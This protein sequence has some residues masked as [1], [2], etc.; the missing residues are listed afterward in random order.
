MRISPRKAVPPKLRNSPAEAEP[1]RLKPLAA[2]IRHALLPG[3]LMGLHVGSAFAGPQGGKVVAGTGSIAR[4]NATST[5]IRQQSKNIAIDW[6]K[7][8]VKSN[9]LVQFKQPGRNAQALNRIF[10][11]NASQIH[12]RIK[13][14]GRVL[15][16]N[17]NGVIFGRTAKVNVNGLVAA[18]MR[19]IPVDDFMAGKY[20]LEA[21]T[22]VDGAVVN[23]GVIEAGPGGDVTLV[24]KSIR[25]DGVI[26]ASA[27]RVNLAAGNKVTLD[28]DGDGLMRFAVDESVLENVQALDDQIANTG[29]IAAEGGEVMMAASA[30]ADVFNHAINNSG[31]VRAGRIDKSGGQ[32]RLVG[33]GPGAS[34]LNTGVVDA[35][36][37]DSTSDAGFVDITGANIR[38]SGR[39]I[40]DA[41]GGDGG[42][43]KLQ[44]TGVTAVTD[45]GV[46]SAV[47]EGKGGHVELLGE[48]VGVLDHATIDASGAAGGGEV[49]IGG[50]YQGANSDVQN[51]KLTVIAENATV[52][53]D[54]TENGD[55]GKVIAW[56]DE[57]TLF[58]GEISAKG[59]P[60]GGD[61]GFVETSGKEYL[62]ARGQVSAAAPEGTGG[63]WLLDPRDITILT[64]ATTA[65]DDSTG[66]DPLAMPTA[67]AFDLS[68]SPHTFDSAADS[69]QADIDQIVASLEGGTSVTITTGATGVAEAGDITVAGS[70]SAD[71]A[72]AAVTLSL[73][74]LND[75]LFNAGL[76]VENTTVG[77][78]T[79]AFDL[80]FGG[81]LDGATLDFNDAT[82]AVDSLSITGSANASGT[83]LVNFNMATVGTATVSAAVNIDL[84]SGTN[85]VRLADG[86]YTNT[87]AF[88]I[89]G[90]SGTE[91][92]VGPNAVNAWT[93]TGVDDAGLTGGATVTLTDVETLTGGS[94]ADTFNIDNTWNGA[95]NGGAGADQFIFADTVQVTGAGTAIDGGT[96]VDT[97]NWSMSVADVNVS[98][99]AIGTSDGVA[100][101]EATITTGTFDNIDA[102][103]GNSNANSSLTGPDGATNTWTIGNGIDDGTND[104]TLGTGGRTLDYTNVP[105]LIGGDD[106]DNFVVSAGTAGTIGGGSG[107]TDTLTG[108][109]AANMFVLT[110][111]NIGTLTGVVGAF[112]NIDALIG[113]A[114]ADTLTFSNATAVWSGSFDGAGGGSDAVSWINLTNAVDVIITEADANGFDG[115]ALEVGD[116]AGDTTTFTDIEMI[117]SSGAGTDSLTL[118]DA[119]T[120][121]DAEWTIVG[122]VDDGTLVVA[123]QTLNFTDFGSWTG[124]AAIDTFNVND[125]TADAT[126]DLTGSIDG[127]GGNDVFDLDG[128][129]TIGGTLIGGTGTADEIAGP[130]AANTW[131]VT[132]DAA[133]NFV[134]GADNVAFTGVERLQGGS[135]TDN[136]DVAAGA[137]N[138]FVD[139]GVNTDTIDWVDYGSPVSVT[140]TTVAAANGYGGAS[141]TGLAGF[142]NIE[143]MLAD[144]V[145]FGSLTLDIA[146]GGTFTLNGI[147][148]ANAYADAGTT[149]TLSF[150]DFRTL[151]GSSAAVD[152][153]DFA[154]SG[155]SDFF[156]L[157]G[158]TA[159]AEIDLSAD[160]TDRLYTL[161]ALNTGVVD[162]LAFSNVRT[163]TA[164]GGDAMDFSGSAVMATID[165]QNSTA[166]GIL[167]AGFSGFSDF[168]GN[169]ANA[170]LRAPDGGVTVNITTDNDGDV[171]AVMF[172]NFENLEGGT[173]ADMF[174]FSDTVTVGDIVG[175]GGADEID[176]SVYVAG[177]TFD[178]S[179]DDTGTVN[180][181]TFTGVG[182]LTGGLGNDMLSIDEGETISG[183]F[184][185]AG[186]SDTIDW[187]GLT[188][189]SLTIAITGQG[190]GATGFAGTE[191]TGDGGGITLSSFDNVEVLTGGPNTDAFTGRDVVG[192][193]FSL[194][195]GAGNSYTD[196]S[197]TVGFS[198]LED[199]T[200]STTNATTFTLTATDNTGAADVVHT[201]DLTGSG[202]DDS[203]IFVNDAQLAGQI[204]AGTGTNDQIDTNGSTL[205]TNEIKIL[206]NGD[207]E[208]NDIIAFGNE[209]NINADKDDFTGIE[210]QTG[211]PLILAGIDDMTNTWI[212][213]GLGAVTLN[214]IMYTNVDSIVL[215]NDVDNV[216]FQAT[217]ELTNGVN[218][219]NSGDDTLI[220]DLAATFT[221][222]DVG[223]GSIDIGVTTNFV[224]IE[225]LTGSAMADMFDFTGGGTLANTLTT[226]G[227]A[228]MLDVSAATGAVTVNLQTNAL[229]LVN[230]GGAGGINTF[231]DLTTVT[232]GGGDDIVIAD[233]T[234][235]TFDITDQDD[236]TVGGVSFIDFSNLQSGTAGDTFQF[237]GVNAEI[238]GTI[239]GDAGNGGTLDYSLMTGG[240]AA[241]VMVN[242]GDSSATLVN[243]GGA[244]GISNIDAVVGADGDDTLRGDNTANVF[245]ITD[246]DDGDIDAGA[247]TFTDFSI[248]E[249]GTAG[250]TFRFNGVSAA[251]TGTVAGDATNGGT[252]DYSLMTGG[253]AL[254][255]DV[256]LET[257]SASLVFAGAASGFTNI[258]AVTGDGAN[259]ALTGANASANTFN[260]TNAN[261]GNIGGAFA[262]T[263]FTILNAGTSGD[264]FVFT[265]TGT[266]DTI[267]GTAGGTDTVSYAS[268][269]GPVSLT[270]APVL[271]F[272]QV[273]TAT[274]INGVVGSPLG[275]TFTIQPGGQLDAGTGIDGGGGSDTV[276]TQESTTET[277]TFSVTGANQGSVSFPA[278]TTFVSIE[279]L[280]GTGNN[281]AFTFTTAASRIANVIDGNGGAAD[282]VT[283]T[284]TGG[285]TVNID[286]TTDA[287]TDID[288]IVGAAADA[289]FFLAGG[290]AFTVTSTDSGSVDGATTTGMTFTNWANLVGTGA[291]DLFDF[292]SGDVSGT[293][294]GLGGS[295]T[296]DFANHDDNSTVVLLLAGTTD[297][298]QGSLTDTGGFDNIDGI[299]GR[300][301]GADSLTGLD[302]TSTWTI[303][304]TPQY[305]AAAVTFDFSEVETI[306]G[307]TLA[308]NFVISN[309]LGITNIDGGADPNPGVDTIDA[310]AY[311]ASALTWMINA[312]GGGS[313]DTTVAINFA[314]IEA[315]VGG[316]MTDAFTVT[317]NSGLLNLFG[318]DPGNV[319]G[320]GGAMNTID[321]SARST[322]V[323]VELPNISNISTVIG[324]TSMNDQLTGTGAADVFT[325]TSATD[326]GTV[327]GG[328]TTIYN[329]FENLAGGG[330]ADD[331]VLNNDVTG[332]VTGDA[333]AD[334]FFVQMN[335][336][337]IGGGIDGGADNDTVI[338]GQA[339]GAGDAGD[340][341]V[342]LTADLVGG[343]GSDTFDFR[344]GSTLVG[345]V[346]G[347]VATAPAG[348]DDD[349][350]TIDD[351]IEAQFSTLPT[352][353]IPTG[354]GS[355]GFGLA[356]DF[357]LTSGTFDNIDT[358][359][360]NGLGTLFGDQDSPNTF[361]IRDEATV[362]GTENQ[363]TLN[364]SVFNNFGLFGGNVDDL[365]IFE[366]TGRI[367]NVIDGGFGGTDTIQA[368]AG[369]SIFTVTGGTTGNIDPDGAGAV[370]STSFQNMDI[371]L[372]AAGADTFNVDTSWSGTVDGG[373]GGGTIDWS[374]AGDQ[375]VT[376]TAAGTN[377]G[378]A[379]TSPGTIGGGFDNITALTNPN[380]GISGLQGP[381]LDTDWTVS[382][383]DSGQVQLNG[384][385]ATNLVFTQ[386]DNLTGGNAVDAFTIGGLHSGNI[387]G[388]GGANSFTFTGAGGTSQITGSITGGTG[389]DTLDYTAFGTAVNIALT[390]VSANGFNGTEFGAFTITTAFNN[391]DVINGN[392]ANADTLTALNVTNLW[393]IA[394]PDGFTIDSGA[395]I[396]TFSDFPN[397]T[398]GTG[399]DSF[400]FDGGTVSGNIDG[401]SGASN[402]VLSYAGAGA[403][404]GI[405]V[406]LNPAS[407]GTTDGFTGTATDITG[408][409]DNI[410]VLVGSGGTDTLNGRNSNVAWEIDGTNRYVGSRTLAFSALENLNGGTGIDAFTVSAAH[411]GSLA[412]GTNDDT[413]T[414][415]GPGAIT[416]TVDGDLGTD[417]LDWA[418]TANSV[419]F[420]LLAM[421][422]LDGSQGD[423]TG[424]IATTG[425]G[426]DNIETFVSDAASS[427]F[428]GLDED[429]TWTVNGL[430]S[431]QIASASLGSL[432]FNNF[433]QSLQGGT[434]V[435]DFIYTAAGQLTGNIDGG[436]GTN[437][438]TAAAL[439][440]PTGNA[441][442]VT[443]AASGR[444]GT[445]D[446]T[447]IPTGT[448]TFD[449][450]AGTWMNITNISG[451]TG[452]DLV[453]ITGAS[454]FAGT[455]DGAGGINDV[456]RGGDAVN[457]WNLTAPGAG[458][459][460]GAGSNDFV[461]FENL[462]GGSMADTFAFTDGS[463]VS[464]IAGAGGTDTLDYSAVTAP[465][466]VNLAASTASLLTAAAPSFDSIEAVIGTGVGGDALT[467]A[468]DANAWNITGSGTGTV[469]GFGF[470]QIE[471]LN[472]GTAVDTFTLN[473]G[474]AIAG[475]INGGG[476][477]DILLGS[478]FANVWD[479]T[480]NNAGTVNGNAFTQIENLS[481]LGSVASLTQSAGVGLSGEMTASTLTLNTATITTGAN[482]FNVVG[483][484][485]SSSAAQTVTAGGPVSVSGTINDAG[486][487]YTINSIGDTTVGGIVTTSAL[488]ANTSGGDYSSGALT[489]GQ[490]TITTAGG[491]FTSGAINS[492]AAVNVNTGGGSFASGAIASTGAT[493]VNAGGG[494]ATIGGTINASAA[495]VT[496]G[497][498]TVGAV[499]TTGAQTYAGPITFGGGLSG[500]TIAIN[501]NG[502]AVSVGGGVNA[503]TLSVD[504][505][506]AALR[507][508][509]TTGS[510][511]YAGATTF[512]GNLSGTAI[513]INGNGGA[514]SV[515]GGVN[516]T[517]L[518]V[519]AGSA[520]LRSVVTTGSQSYAGATT[521]SGNLSGTAITMNGRGG[522]VTVAGTING[523]S[524]SLASG[525]GSVRTVTT[526][527]AQTYSGPIAFSGDLTGANLVFNGTST[528]SGDIVLQSSTDVF[529]FNAPVTGTGN[530]DILPTANTDIF[531]GNGSGAGHI[532]SN[533]FTGFQGHLIIGALLNP[534]DSPAEDAIV[535]M[536]PNVTADL[537]TVERDFRVGGDVTLIGS[538]IE[539][540][541]SVGGV[542]GSGQVTLV[543]VG[544]SQNNGGDAPGDIVGPPTGTSIISGNKAVLIANNTVTNAGNIQL[545]LNGGDLFL[546]VSATEDEPTFDPTSNATSVTFD[547][548]TV[549]IIISL[550][551]NLQS[552]QVFFTNPAAA[553]TGL[554]N[555]Q[556]IDVG[557]FEE[558]LSL[559]GVIGNGIAMSLDQCEEAEGCAP[560]ISEEELDALIAQIEGR[561]AEIKKRLEAGTIDP[562]Q[563][564]ELLA[565]FERELANF[566]TY[567]TQLTEFAESEE[568]YSDDD[569]GELDDF[570]EEFDETFED[571]FAEPLETGEP[572]GPELVA[573]DPV[574][575]EPL[576]EAFEELDEAPAPVEEAPDADE[577]EELEE[578]L[579]DDFDQPVIEEA[580]GEFED[581]EE[582]SD[583]FEELGQRIDEE[584][585]RRL[586]Q[587]VTVT[588]TNGV[589]GI[590]ENGR[591]TWT[592]D[593]VLPSFARRY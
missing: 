572:T 280:T 39:V 67:G 233:N 321:F 59:G 181:M 155:Y 168:T 166:A 176:L 199:L 434:Q 173:G 461:N 108:D 226:G 172:T 501:G 305:T 25:N 593:I 330:G 28:F 417:T 422:S 469:D 317:G 545:A 51:A 68:G 351:V 503:T 197:R 531:I 18:G 449:T 249:S 526:T 302:A 294:D 577:F 276:V 156:V 513:T 20:K 475:S 440:A 488:T 12:G 511:S 333:G 546:A 494:T 93:I 75:I 530:L 401:G 127:A 96:D 63:Q 100:G 433:A 89:T 346:Q 482:P 230:G 570:G 4:P 234:A 512:S 515:G 162:S 158:G 45:S 70:I 581:L 491:Q 281:D 124:D 116:G 134:V 381:G 65:G 198:A 86:V 10:D 442:V 103:V 31:V 348:S 170:T 151:T 212:V 259:D 463:S 418:G 23:E 536:P 444:L 556:F 391:I 214:A 460:G 217:G 528:F 414:F 559:F 111:D 403:T 262:F 578:E 310:S 380:S 149:T 241:T 267:N 26:I 299:V 223:D 264:T 79:L 126:D 432:Q 567:K 167:D 296:V 408:T 284:A 206:G 42:D 201:G 489:T 131:N 54:A 386:F 481:A 553:L 235:N 255:A 555:V 277:G 55:G 439:A 466:T 221:I 225:S 128:G 431:F 5:V 361:I 389:V 568:G 308:D 437:S 139:G 412:G 505:G 56:S 456:F 364:G 297:G 101:D 81:D 464:R 574:E 288:T 473:V 215:A 24:G 66:G 424:I 309:G 123:G 370:M 554:Q 136:F 371:L 547:P 240:Q 443:G 21:L 507:S 74:A 353:V 352:D 266:I 320:G 421:G 369:G 383:G 399:I 279:N 504:A 250:D 322:D 336:V 327:S 575:L 368:A 153:F 292:D 452:V 19:N 243:S 189:S 43:I 187:S 188:T 120:A 242:L 163:L 44:S 119:T 441:F 522:A 544:D 245:N 533:Q 202:G 219:S 58:H 350:T 205:T 462:V 425:P 374:V 527:G 7:F 196:G 316:T 429:T 1:V 340:V 518:S 419:T 174:V 338:I 564:R 355:T 216:T 185:G 550:G 190:S 261:D 182:T 573:P 144:N 95:L 29:T 303:D 92:V 525:N 319:D 72:N 583:E 247:F 514:V 409:F 589:V 586:T 102:I 125:V 549:P 48:R 16:M 560:N 483:N 84:G 521:F 524:L 52:R 47:G 484:L 367:T 382:G 502:G 366:A 301:G 178:L 329:D 307:G 252:L 499:T 551:L 331:F 455:I 107:G 410:D 328:I 426:F 379:G 510:Q 542:P 587:Y 385:A 105:T 253:T 83:D 359:N 256:N 80:Q 121:V 161:S 239:T 9:E 94:M 207:G 565:G 238:T 175:N 592:G 397:L 428:L 396:G 209:G 148:M 236:F 179:G 445:I 171:G 541:A 500:T 273:T 271:V 548:E 82:L 493:T 204:L 342:V 387:G 459:I 109:N 323:V 356:G 398:G 228:D 388:S 312:D 27:G 34:V 263:D 569:F 180:G 77:T 486:S 272:P 291:G 37:G 492:G 376:L 582:E 98:V 186:G 324:G 231:G 347:S 402:D 454:S 140:A 552:V 298:Y 490:A 584:L 41:S 295:D 269:T 571:D 343:T 395:A 532:A 413:F 450:L 471:T 479:V 487:A 85:E 30:A 208:A 377:I 91:T 260:I 344:D 523:T 220:A 130:D 244:A 495:N 345:T 290:T 210:A 349:G 394:G 218:G 585:I 543:A 138:V 561:I 400:V 150:T 447:T 427:T 35:S 558:E 588:R 538:N 278:S 143:T 476:A 357:D 358:I 254:S 117:T 232:G 146:A 372:G 22:G 122:G 470:S 306:I 289:D 38:N 104:G 334:E 375:N 446:I 15:L 438:L 283:Y 274:N 61:G 76:T 165:L 3:L 480:G 517:T 498:A 335:S 49:L 485:V 286:G 177:Q 132:G 497:G 591:V 160:T 315:F 57:S 203:F 285:L 590:G 539:L 106:V 314:D 73:V 2:H 184:D 390:A 88:T 64:I 506:S 157:D 287:V 537:I 293:I 325:T 373:A 36:A 112:S 435:D 436:A 60:E 11:Q 448:V 50:D 519:D 152:V 393:T 251:V 534:L 362:A 392:V 87:G 339:M 222:S 265:D 453:T 133:G 496:S 451:N 407:L 200:G 118:T 423:T 159:T 337:A 467:G 258:S 472:G 191:T 576:E 237:N 365:F 40:A 579:Q 13:A 113:N 474:G 193:S 313:V 384:M 282:T 270:I 415:T 32:I 227:G 430:N 78:G 468:N 378:F 363:G 211:A 311:S 458:N 194:D 304:G 580:P 147:S 457:A 192:T 477:G 416:G 142:A 33:L 71:V 540:G 529:D 195:D 135:D 332:T 6:Q 224:D 129:A 14:N 213:T 341:A 62:D 566:E 326:D 110:G 246:S 405:T 557:L 563:G 183:V 562:E 46:V 114:M 275:D 97:I 420:Q 411:T 360:G 145:N 508:V 478:G 406:T 248:L 509:L 99:S 69:A 17:P 164:G 229:S 535:V 465:V 8:N 141:A 404:M 257:S 354:L 137:A 300:T 115:T 516:A 53:A 154:A 318:A 90:T 169:G 520:A 268:T